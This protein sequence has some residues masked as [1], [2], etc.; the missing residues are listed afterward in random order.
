[1]RWFIYS[2]LKS[3]VGLL[4]APGFIVYYLLYVLI[5]P[6]LRKNNEKL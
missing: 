6:W 3:L 1:M 5:A 2:L 4:L